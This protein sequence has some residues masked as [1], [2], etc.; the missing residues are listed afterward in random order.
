[1]T[2]QDMLNQR[3]R[4]LDDLLDEV[5]QLKERIKAILPSYTALLKEISQLPEEFE[6][7]YRASWIDELFQ[8]TRKRYEKF[9][10]SC[11]MISLMGTALSNAVAMAMRQP[12][13]GLN[14][15]STPIPLYIAIWPSG[16][17]NPVLKD[18]LSR[19]VEVAAVNFQEFEQICLGLKDDVLKGKLVPEAESDIPRLIY[20]LALE[21]RK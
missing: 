21:R 17:I 15:V 11:G 6:R 10:I 12:V 2:L 5:R 14:Q 8:K 1:M 4:S 20:K 19:Q 18:D 16:E 7:R 3:E 13:V 9:L